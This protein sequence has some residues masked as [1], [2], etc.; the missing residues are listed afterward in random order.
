MARP[1]HYVPALGFDAL[2]RFYDPLIA[3]SLR[4][5]KLKT[6]L[7]EQAR[8]AAGHDVLDV[9]CGT[10]TLALLAKQL[11]P[12]A[13]VTGLDGDPAVL[14][15]ARRKLAR[16]GVDVTLVHG[17]ANDSPVFEPASFDRVL[18]SL[19]LHHLTHDQRRSALAAMRRCL[20]PGGELHVL[21][22]WPQDALP[23]KA[24]SRV[25]GWFDGADRLA[26]NWGGR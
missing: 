22:F 20:R 15:I 13:R 5:R 6:R 16:A 10:G 9:G 18:T 4:E 8:I 24:I 7:I 26:D 25:V 3:L 17:L 21:D 12:G 14:A 2:T 11:V 23:M 19:M 1:D